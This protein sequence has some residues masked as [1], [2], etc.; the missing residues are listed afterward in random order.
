MQRGLVRLAA[1]AAVCAAA[2][3]YSVARA[4]AAPIPIGSLDSAYTQSFDSLAAAGT[5]STVP[6]G[7]AFAEAGTNA[8]STYT[9]GTGSGNAGDTYS[10]GAAVST[11]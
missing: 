11:D 9:A 1:C 4:E 6:D 2:A 5:S 8:N 7:W 10:F 3:L